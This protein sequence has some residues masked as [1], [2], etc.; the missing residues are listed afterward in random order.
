MMG[1]VPIRLTAFAIQPPTMSCTAIELNSS[2]HPLR[3]HAAISLLWKRFFANM[4]T[5]E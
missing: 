4:V 1:S 5:K 3:N 2:M